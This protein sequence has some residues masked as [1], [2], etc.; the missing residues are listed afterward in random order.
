[1][2]DNI[3][4]PIEI[5]KLTIAGIVI[6]GLLMMIGV[7]ALFGILLGAPIAF[8]SMGLY[9]IVFSVLIGYDLFCMLSGIACIAGGIFVGYLLWNN[10]GG[11]ML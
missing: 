10:G 1:M 4:K 11:R 2:K 7:L 9:M 8:I 3:P 5:S 6:L